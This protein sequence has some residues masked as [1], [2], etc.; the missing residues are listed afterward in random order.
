MLPPA[1]HALLCGVV[2]VA[3]LYLVPSKVRALPRND[4]THV[5]WRMAMV[6]PAMAISTILANVSA[7][8][9]KPLLQQIGISIAC[10]TPASSLLPVGLIMCLFL[11]PLV[12]VVIDTY[13]LSEARS[14]AGFLLPA[15]MSVDGCKEHL[16]AR[17]FSLLVALR[18]ADTS[19]LSL[20]RA[21]VVAP[22]AEEW[23][24]RACVLPVFAAHGAGLWSAICGASLPFGLA[25]LHHG[26]EL[27][28]RGFSPLQAALSVV[29]QLGYTTLFGAIA[30]F[31][32]LRTGNLLGVVL[33][34]AFCNLMGFPDFM[35]LAEFWP[36]A[37]AGSADKALHRHPHPHAPHK[38]LLLVAYVAGLAG[39]CV[40]L[41]QLGRGAAWHSHSE[42]YPCALG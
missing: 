8:A 23:V 11:G 2:F 22:V 32:Q 31:M 18:V 34:H 26:Y 17:G 13:R 24:F 38:W 21:L 36:T 27:L 35:W 33:A 15:V 14:M 10:L 20:F 40:L 16:A 1:L 42:R 28:R 3:L 6:V 29:A 30:A 19:S 4:P 9:D 39:F 7:A 41:P 12:Q 25:H 37:G 5:L